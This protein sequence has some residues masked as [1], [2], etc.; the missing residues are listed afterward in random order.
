MKGLFWFLFAYCLFE[1][2]GELFISRRNQRA[3]RAKGFIETES[4]GGMVAMIA[5]HV[6]WYVSL[7]IEG[8]ARPLHVSTLV[9]I[10]ALTLFMLAQG[11]RFWSLTSLGSFWNV[12]V[13]T[14]GGSENNFISSGPYRYIRHPNYLVVI[15]ELCTLPLIGDAPITAVLF[16][17]ANGILLGRRIPLEEESLFKI[18]G[19][20]DS[21][22]SKPRLIPNLASPRCQ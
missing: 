20:R 3:M 7:L 6:A 21:M 22:G 12:S 16:T 8:L 17:L 5:L 14:K 11:L 19:Y 10:V 9:Q 2:V 1:R 13:L 18:P 15:L 4:K